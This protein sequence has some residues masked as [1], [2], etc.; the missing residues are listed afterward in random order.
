VRNFWCRY[1]CPYGALLGLLAWVGPTHIRRDAETCIGCGR[2]TAQCP[3]GIEVEKKVV[4]RSPECIGCA[5]CV[6][7]CPVRGCLA[8]T[9]PGRR[10]V[11]WQ[12]VSIGTVLV[13][14]LVWA[15]AVSTGHWD[16]QVPP[17]MLK[18]IYLTA[19]GPM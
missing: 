18:R 7:S 17:A 16:S 2:C 6:G 19:L 4:V 13:L 9:V 5:E 10:A 8:F 12:I 3:S 14:L 1:L 11:P 15:W